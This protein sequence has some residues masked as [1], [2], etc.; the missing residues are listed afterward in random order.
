[1][2]AGNVSAELGGPIIKDKLWFFGSYQKKARETD[3]V[4]AATG[5]FMRTVNRDEKL[6]FLKLTWQATENDRLV[7]SFREVGE[8]VVHR[9]TTSHAVNDTRRD[10]RELWSRQWR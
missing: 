3:V 10:L 2:L 1:M 7:A 8:F 9:V 5:Q 4:D 6:G